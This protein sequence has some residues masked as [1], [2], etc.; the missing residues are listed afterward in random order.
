[1]VTALEIIKDNTELDY[2]DALLAAWAEIMEPIEVE[3]GHIFI[4]EG[5][6]KYKSRF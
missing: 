4:K 2:P 6:G 3:D 1:M 5:E